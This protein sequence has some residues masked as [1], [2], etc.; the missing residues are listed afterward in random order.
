MKNKISL[1]KFSQIPLLYYKKIIFNIYNFDFD[2]VS[3]ENLQK[4]SH[5][6]KLL[7][8]R[9]EQLMIMN[10]IFNKNSLD[11]NL[12]RYEDLAWYFYNEGLLTK[13]INSK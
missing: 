2:K 3:K 7:I 5:Y 11:S 12:R 1:N 4:I 13:Y 10:I 6:E 9:T 8:E